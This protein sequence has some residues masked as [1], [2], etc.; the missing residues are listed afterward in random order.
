M[1][2]CVW[3]GQLVYKRGGPIQYQR[4]YENLKAYSS[5]LHARTRSFHAQAG[6]H[7]QNNIWIIHA[8]SSLAQYALNLWLYVHT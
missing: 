6:T 4:D 1:T 3:P 2:I 5:T 7:K 8:R